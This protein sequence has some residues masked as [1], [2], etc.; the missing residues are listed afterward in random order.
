MTIKEITLKSEWENFLSQCEEKT[1]LNS[2]NWGEFQKKMGETIW[3]L[4]VYDNDHLLAVSLVVKVQA[5]RGTFLFVPHGPNIKNYP[6][7]IKNPKQ[8]QNPKFQAL[9]ALLF[10]LKEIAK[11]EGA[12]FI[13]IAPILEKNGEN[14]KIFRELRFRAAPTHM[15]PEVTWELHITPSQEELLMGMRKTTRYLIRQAQKNSDIEIRQGKDRK[16][17]ESFYNLHRETVDRHHFTPFPFE[18]I[19]KEFESFAPDNEIIVFQGFFRG[20]LLASAIV[21]F[22]QDCA[23]YHH[24]ATSLRYPKIPIAYL[25]QWEIIREA[26]RRGC[27]RYNFWGIAPISATSQTENSKFQIPK[28]HP[29]YGLTLFKMGF[30]GHKKEYVR[31]QDLPLSWRYFPTA[32]FEFLRRKKRGL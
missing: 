3:R 16:D 9:N 6:A 28:N 24:G 8:I 22:W 31:T 5:R 20:E 18:Y 4:G 32:F 21:V 2:W 11:K 7:P 27:A 10:K 30:G 19:K 15:H 26:K 13:R 14:E 25:L 29:W 1:F 23:F 17:V 12:S